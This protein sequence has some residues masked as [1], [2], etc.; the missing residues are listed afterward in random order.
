M[1]R[2]STEVVVVVRCPGIPLAAHA[3]RIFEPVVA[4]AIDGVL[5]LA[6]E[7]QLLVSPFSSRDISRL[8]RF[9]PKTLEPEQ[10]L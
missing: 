5:G 1:R 6:G 4:D 10:R 2:F 3:G 7:L 9:F 8:H